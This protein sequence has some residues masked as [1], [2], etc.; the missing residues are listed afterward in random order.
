VLP[1]AVTRGSFRLGR[2]RAAPRP[3][4]T[5]GR[6][7]VFVMAFAA[8]I[9]LGYAGDGQLRRVRLPSLGTAAVFAALAAQAATSHVPARVE[10]VPVRVAATVLGYAFV[11]A[12]L[13]TV[14]RRLR[15]GG[16]LA[17]AAV[18]LLAIGWR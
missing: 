2:T 1:S 14:A 7:D 16:L 17:S 10:G 15:A 13:V 9:V 6:A 12:F 3:S 18:A 8:G 11:A 5:F 4:H